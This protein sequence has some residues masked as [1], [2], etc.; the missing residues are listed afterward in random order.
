MNKDDILNAIYQLKHEDKPYHE[1][2][3]KRLINEYDEYS[4]SY[5]GDGTD[6]TVSDKFNK[7]LT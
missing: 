1:S 2:I 5:E 3:I 6:L 4:V 7:L